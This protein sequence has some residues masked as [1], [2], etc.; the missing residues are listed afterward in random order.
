MIGKIIFPKDRG[1][2]KYITLYKIRDFIDMV[3]IEM[4]RFSE[5]A[6]YNHNGSYR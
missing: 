5:W 1:I 2:Y 4:E 3:D 6:Q